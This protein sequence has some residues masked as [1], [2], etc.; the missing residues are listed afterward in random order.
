[1]DTSHVDYLN[2]CFPYGQPIFYMDSIA[3]HAGEL[4][5]GIRPGVC[6]K[7]LKESNGITM[8]VEYSGRSINEHC[9]Y[10]TKIVNNKLLAVHIGIRP[11]N[12]VSKTIYRKNIIGGHAGRKIIRIGYTLSYTDVEDDSV[13]TEHTDEGSNNAKTTDSMMPIPGFTMISEGEFI[14]SLRA[15]KWRFLGAKL[16]LCC[17]QYVSDENDFT[18]EKVNRNSVIKNLNKIRKGSF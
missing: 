6:S 8:D 13:Y 12:S 18:V 3:F 10:G 16:A 7:A 4:Y 2:N 11:I 1:M 9:Y 14:I 5:V 15:K 17:G